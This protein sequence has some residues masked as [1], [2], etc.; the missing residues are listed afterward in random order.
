M[1]MSRHVLFEMDR[2]HVQSR[3]SISRLTVPRS[4]QLGMWRAYSLMVGWRRIV[5]GVA[6]ML[7]EL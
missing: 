7:V 6:G 5:L 4:C 1:Y 2:R 3:Y